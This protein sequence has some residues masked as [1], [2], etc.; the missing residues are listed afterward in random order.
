MTRCGLLRDE[1]SKSCW[2]EHQT[3]ATMRCV[4]ELDAWRPTT[5]IAAA[6]A[7]ALLL[8]SCSTSSK[9]TV[10]SSAQPIS[11]GGPTDSA[12][13]S[14]VQA[15]GSPIS[16]EDAAKINAA[17]GR[18]VDDK[19]YQMP[20]GQ[21]VLIKGGEPLPENVNQAVYG[22][23]APPVSTAFSTHEFDAASQEAMNAAIAV[24]EA[25]TG[26]NVVVVIHGM[27]AAPGGGGTPMWGVAGGNNDYT[28]TS[29]EEAI[30]AA[31]KWVD[32]SPNGR[33]IIV[34]DAVG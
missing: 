8:T 22:S 23:V 7:C 21:Y 26:R 5:L 28:G 11:S 10:D 32:Q 33:M 1:T 27:G 34:V 14:P 15:S 24:Q 6:V 16:A 30:A 20:D 3:H 25:A 13:S 9:P 17:W 2:H 12:T 31:Q 19:A 18:V 29:R 4:T